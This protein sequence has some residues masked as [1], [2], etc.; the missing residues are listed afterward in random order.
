MAWVYNAGQRRVRRSPQS[1]YDSPGTASDGLRTSDNLDMFN[2]SPDR[3]DWKLNGKTE[4]YI[5]Y[6]NYK[7]DSPA[8]KYTQIIQPGH[9]NQ[10]LVRYELHRVW[11]V[12][13]TLKSGERHVYSKR[14]FYIDEDTWQVAEADHYDG[15][16]VLWR[17]AEAFSEY[18]YDVQMPWFVAEALYDLNSG[19]YW[20][21]G[22]KNEQK[23]AY[24]FSYRASSNDFSP[25]SL[26]L[27]GV[28]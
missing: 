11:H 23:S 2:G 4:I 19:R 5:P 7:L 20:I 24:D 26:R 14:D 15:R 21:I 17:V 13:A 9:I 3:Y 25:G 22:L 12:T 28:R 8:L 18:L 27:Q 10:D 16:G 1:A 6:N